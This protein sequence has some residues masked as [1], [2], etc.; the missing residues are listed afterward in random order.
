M[1]EETR[2]Q[3]IETE[4]FSNY[5]ERDNLTMGQFIKKE[6]RNFEEHG[7]VDKVV[8]EIK[9]E[10]IEFGHDISQRMNEWYS[11]P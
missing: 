7:N 6:I 2:F 5:N 9:R 3:I 10:V 11:S 8:L 4:M 1:P